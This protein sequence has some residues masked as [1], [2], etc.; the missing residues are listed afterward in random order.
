MYTG[1]YHAGTGLSLLVPV[2]GNIY[3]AIAYIDN[4]VGFF[5]NCVV[6]V[7]GGSTYECYGQV[8]IKV[9]PY[10]IDLCQRAGLGI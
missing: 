6:T 10:R 2:K 8:S 3:T 5:V 7:W 9:S 4:L 1:Q